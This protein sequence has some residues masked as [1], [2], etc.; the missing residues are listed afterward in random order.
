MQ[1]LRDNCDFKNRHGNYVKHVYHNDNDKIDKVAF[2][3]EYYL[4]CDS[5]RFIVTYDLRDSID[6]FSFV[7]EKMKREGQTE[8]KKKK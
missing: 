8:I 2:V 4:K 6:L 1:E 5:L 7:I 3:Y